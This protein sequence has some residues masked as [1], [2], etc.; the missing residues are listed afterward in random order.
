MQYSNSCWLDARGI[1]FL[2]LSGAHQIV[3]LVEL[4]GNPA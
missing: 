2:R 4:A 1:S 3:A